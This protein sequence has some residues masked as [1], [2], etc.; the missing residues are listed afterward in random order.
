MPL[1][2]PAGVS[3]HEN[4]VGGVEVSKFPCFCLPDKEQGPEW[5]GAGVV[6][7]HEGDKSSISIAIDAEVS[8]FEMQIRRTG[9]PKWDL[10]EHS[11]KSA[12][13]SCAA[14]GSRVVTR[15]ER[16]RVG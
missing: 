1:G 13:H 7:K 4:P 8:W 16:A 10:V 14:I 9:S 11:A 6:R 5:C 2:A 15:V 3:S 12:Q